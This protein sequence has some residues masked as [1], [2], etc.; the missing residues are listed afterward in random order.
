MGTLAFTNSCRFILAHTLSSY[1]I[2]LL[3]IDLYPTK[4][5]AMT[6]LLLLMA[7]FGHS[8]AINCKG[9]TPLDSLSFDKLLNKF[10]VSLI[11]FD[12]AYPYGDKH[13]EFAKF[14]QDAVDIE[15]LFVG[16]VGIKDYGDKDN[17]DLG[18]RY[19]VKKDDY[20]V[21]ILFMKDE[22]TGKM[23]DYRFGDEFKV[24][25]LKNFVRQRT[26]IYMALPGCME[27]FDNL[28]D[29]LMTASNAGEK[30][31]VVVEAEKNQRQIAR[32]QGQKG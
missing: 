4:M 2:Q 17:A 23:T 26:G 28:A 19:D 7:F 15:D 20:P 31:K 18:E 6:H 24:D 13:E 9:C 11:K 12:V 14:S 3:F 1:N 22:K 5:A 16:E 25:N 29:K 32:R 30:G 21:V 8:L 27:D 10:K